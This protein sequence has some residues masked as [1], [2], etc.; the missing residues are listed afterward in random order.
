M[1]DR[2][3]YKRSTTMLQVILAIVWCCC[4]RVCYSI[5]VAVFFFLVT[6]TLNWLTLHI[7][8]Y[9]AMGLNPFIMES[10]FPFIDDATEIKWQKNGLRFVELHFHGM[11]HRRR[12][13]RSNN[14]DNAGH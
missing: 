3:S 11:Q 4:R 10:A 1:R 9:T 2:I 12:K 8:V 13:N 6:F 14:D 5:A 7:A